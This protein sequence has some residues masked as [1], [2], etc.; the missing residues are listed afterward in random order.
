MVVREWPAGILVF[1]PY[2]LFGQDVGVDVGIS[3]VNE[4]NELVN[5]CEMVTVCLIPNRCL[6]GCGLGEIKYV[7]NGKVT[8][9]W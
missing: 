4:F 6:V 9:L 8:C 2:V 7:L 1:Y 5:S 3:L